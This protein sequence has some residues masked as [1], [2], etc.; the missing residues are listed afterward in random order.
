MGVRSIFVM[1][2]DSIGLSG[3]GP[4]H[5][6]IEQLA[7]LRAMPKLNAFRPCDPVETL[8]CWALALKSDRRPLGQVI[9]W[10]RTGWLQTRWRCR[11]RHSQRQPEYET[12]EA[13][14]SLPK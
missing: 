7:A 3:D 11:S 4:T 8:E 13:K 5:Q 14:P 12:V 2:H 9:A 6:P 1:T 10:S